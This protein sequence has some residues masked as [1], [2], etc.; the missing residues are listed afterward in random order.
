[1]K[2]NFYTENSIENEAFVDST[3]IYM[4][5]TE[6]FGG[7]VIINIIIFPNVH[8]VTPPAV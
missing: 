6:F 2:T 4:S 7:L 3:F 8:M 1:M 5:I